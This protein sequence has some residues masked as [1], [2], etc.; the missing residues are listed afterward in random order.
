MLHQPPF[1]PAEIELAALCFPAWAH[2]GKAK[3]ITD[4]WGYFVIWAIDGRRYRKPANSNRPAK[5]ATHGRGK[6]QCH[7]SHTSLDGYAAQFS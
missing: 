7:D 5:G 2:S 6:P 1:T 3:G 4:W